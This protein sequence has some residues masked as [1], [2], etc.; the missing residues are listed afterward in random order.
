MPF[1][2]AQGSGAYL[3]IALFLCWTGRRFLCQ[4][5]INAWRCGG[6]EDGDPLLPGTMWTWLV[7]GGMIAFAAVALAGTTPFACAAMLCLLAVASLVY[8]RIRAQ[9]GLPLSY[10]VPRRDIPF[11]LVDAV[12]TSPLLTGAAGRGLAAF[13]LM[14]V[15]TRLI[16][17]Q[18]VA[19]QL[20]GFRMAE[21]TG[22]RRR[23][24]L[25]TLAGSVGL[26]IA[27]G[28][29]SHLTAYYHYGANLLDGGTTEGGWRTRQAL[30][31]YERLE[32]LSKAKVG[33][34]WTPTAFRA[35]GLGLSLALMLLRTRYLRFPLNPLGL[36]IAGTFGFH[37]WFPL[38]IAWLVKATVLRLGG[39]Q[40]FRSLRPAFLGLAVG[41]FLI[42]GAV[43][44]LVG[45][46]SETAA[47]R[48]LV[49]FA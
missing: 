49:W 29:W 33:P 7:L 40:A 37:T 42:A 34:N 43:W 25:L 30:L 11:S 16:V 21:L 13:S 45:A 14:T 19:T 47:Q 9:T 41:H 24:L 23:D 1:E 22:L 5:L 35:I 36:A 6:D 2:S 20:E 12:G 18:M 10:V 27:L 38:L 28:Y 17:P 31:E 15:M 8:S 39:P 44:G 32:Q 46:W 4:T 48:Y 26:G 3:G